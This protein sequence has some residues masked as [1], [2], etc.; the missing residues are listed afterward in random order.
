[1][2]ESSGPLGAE[3]LRP[4]LDRELALSR[5]GGDLQLL[6]EIAE[7]FLGDSD[8]MMSEVD[9]AV[10]LNDAK[11]LDRAAHTIKGCVSNFGA[12]ALYDAAL[13]LERMGRSGDLTD[14]HPR[15]RTLQLEMAQ[16]VTDLRGLTAQPG[17]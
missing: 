2:T 6:Q 10:E 1:M 12:Q 7:L 9:R 13:T 17:A 5:V 14:L 11:A 16:L 15:Y 4:A 3:P 8:R